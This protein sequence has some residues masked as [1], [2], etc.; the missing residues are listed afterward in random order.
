MKTAIELITE[1]RRRHTDVEG[2][3]AVHD[4]RHT[5]GELA[6]AAATYIL[7]PHINPLRESHQTSTGIFL[8]I[9]REVFWPFY[10]HEFKPTPNDRIRELVKAGALVVAEIERL[11]RINAQAEGEAGR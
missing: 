3:T 2:W 9:K 7:P 10:R 11:Q 4:D 8:S 1:E 6:K 5:D